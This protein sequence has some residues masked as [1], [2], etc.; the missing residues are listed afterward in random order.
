MDEWRVLRFI[1]NKF[2]LYYVILYHYNQSTIICKGQK[3][4]PGK[5]VSLSNKDNEH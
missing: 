3:I 2:I 4:R 1:K 5:N